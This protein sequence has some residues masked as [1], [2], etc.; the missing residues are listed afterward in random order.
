[1]GTQQ[2]GALVQS[3]LPLFENKH[4]HPFTAHKAIPLTIPGARHV[5]RSSFRADS[6]LIVETRLHED[7]MKNP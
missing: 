4:A 2:N 7:L 3:V 5:A 1:M 6:A